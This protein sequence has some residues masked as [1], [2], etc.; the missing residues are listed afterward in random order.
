MYNE[1]SSLIMKR[2]SRYIWR[3]VD[4]FFQLCQTVYLYSKILQEVQVLHPSCCKIILFTVAWFLKYRKCP[5]HSICTILY[6]GLHLR[7]NLPGCLFLKYTVS[8]ILNDG[9]CLSMVFCE[10]L[11]WFSSNVFLA[12]VK[13][14]LWASRLSILEFGSLKS[15][16]IGFKSWCKGRLGSLP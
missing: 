14:S 2:Y 8:P 12:M 7:S 15:H 4:I 10:V 13:A 11:Q 6:P 1:W 5:S 3:V 16:C 9:G